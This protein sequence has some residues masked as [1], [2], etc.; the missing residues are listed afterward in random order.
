MMVR[1]ATLGMIDFSAFDPEDDRWRRRL[2]WTLQEL[3][4]QQSRD[5]LQM[6]H[7]HWITLAS[8][9]RL[10]PESFDAAKTNAGIALNRMMKLTYPWLADDIGE[11][12]TQQQTEQIVKDY[13]ERFGRPGEPRYDEM[14]RTLRK[15]LQHKLTPAEKLRA[16]KQRQERYRQRMLAQGV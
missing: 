11:S 9:G 1:A 2:D 6:R 10:T 13:Q 5:L 7:N 14:V 16:R 3:E 4:S 12:G 8:H 15:K